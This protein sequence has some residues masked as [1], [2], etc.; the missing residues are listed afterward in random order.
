MFR[1]TIPASGGRYILRERAKTPKIWVQFVFDDLAVDVNYN[2]L[3]QNLQEKLK[4]FQNKIRREIPQ[5]PYDYMKALP[6]LLH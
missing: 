3:S 4:C 5:F 1:T 6:H 2:L